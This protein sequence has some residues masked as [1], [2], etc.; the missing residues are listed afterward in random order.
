MVTTTDTIDELANQV[1]NIAWE[2]NQI[3][4]GLVKNMPADPPEGYEDCIDDLND[5]KKAIVEA[6]DKLNCAWHN[7]EKGGA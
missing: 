7:A 1:D 2:V 5:A 6:V 3:V 4:I